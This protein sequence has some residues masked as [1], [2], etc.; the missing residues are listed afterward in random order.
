MKNE[1]TIIERIINRLWN[2]ILELEVFI[3]HLTG[4]IPSHNFRKFMYMLGGIQI[5]WGSTIH[6]GAR[7]YDPRNIVI[8]EDSII[9]EY[10]VLDGRDK[11]MIGDHVALATGV[12]I[13][14]SKHD[15]NDKNFKPINGPVVIGDYVFIGPRAIILP[16]VRIGRGA[17]VAA[18]AVV[19]KDIK[20]NA[21]VAGVPAEK[22]G[23]RK[24]K[25]L[26]YHLGRPRLF[27]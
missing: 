6:M 7:F 15:I 9:G 18:G 2:I 16:G 23:E 26:E 10:A 27:R 14:N 25:K 4:Y 11:L 19:T 20:P 24:L 22:I 21:I 12:M 8:G 1:K 13:Y 5:G 17:V 3:L